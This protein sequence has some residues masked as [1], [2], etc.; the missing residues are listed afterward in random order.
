MR[1]K[2]ITQATVVLSLFSLTLLAGGCGGE[3]KAVEACEEACLEEDAC[4]DAISYSDDFCADACAAAWDAYEE[5]DCSAEFRSVATCQAASNTCPVPDCLA[6]TRELERCTEDSGGAATGTCASLCRDAS[7]CVDA[8]DDF[9][10][11]ACTESCEEAQDVA[12][13]EGCRAEYN[14]VLNCVD[15]CDAQSSTEDC[16]GEF[17]EYV[18]CMG[19]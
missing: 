12:A 18:S 10:T 8:G 5:V 15:A 17:E 9:D 6:E 11:D 14:L 3:T 13:G 7:R 1:S 2:T 16:P 19:G 4:N